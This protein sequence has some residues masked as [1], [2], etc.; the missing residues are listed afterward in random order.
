MDM[1]KVTRMVLRT[2]MEVMVLESRIRKWKVLSS[3]LQPKT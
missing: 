3:S 2:I 1:L